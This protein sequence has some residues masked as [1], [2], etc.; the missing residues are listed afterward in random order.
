MQGSFEIP[1]VSV[2]M[3]FHQ[4]LGL[5]TCDQRMGVNNLIGFDELPAKA[6]LLL[7]D[8][9]HHIEHLLTFLQHFYNF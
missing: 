5:R 6:L 9:V 8:M 3:H 1:H 7:G 2:D 4:Q